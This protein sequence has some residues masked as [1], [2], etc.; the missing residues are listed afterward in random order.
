MAYRL[1]AQSRA[2]LVGVHPKMVAVVERAILKSAVDFSVSE[3]VR[4]PERQKELYAQ[5][6]SKPGPKVTWTLAS[7]HF[8]NAKTGYGHAV[9]L[10]SGGLGRS[11]PVPE[12]RRHRQGH[13]RG[14]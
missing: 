2:R 10:G 8:K 13:V 11:S 6:R 12:V 9:D 1:G 3:G 4:T 7:N 14:C 5:G